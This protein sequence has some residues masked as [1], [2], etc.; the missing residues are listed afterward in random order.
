MSLTLVNI[1]QLKAS[2]HHSTDE[3]ATGSV[4]EPSNQPARQPTLQWLSVIQTASHSIS[5]SE[6]SST[7][8]LFGTSVINS[9][10]VNSWRCWEYIILTILYLS[11]Y[12]AVNKTKFNL[13]LILR[14]QQLHLKCK[15]STPLTDPMTDI[16][17][18]AEHCWTQQCVSSCY[19]TSPVRTSSS[20][21]SAGRQA[22]FL[23]LQE[24]INGLTCC[25]PSWHIATTFLDFWTS[26][27][28]DVPMG[29]RSP[30]VCKGRAEKVFTCALFS[31]TLSVS[32]VRKATHLVDL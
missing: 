14:R 23:M 16:F 7:E 18:M 28:D 32:E 26:P 13:K 10:H 6:P 2:L 29:R 25:D 19:R 17:V 21:Q 27:P 11:D 3:L 20:Q 1:R 30:V 15:T 31:L 9:D 12:F 5:Q 4:R 8:L 22:W 24:Q